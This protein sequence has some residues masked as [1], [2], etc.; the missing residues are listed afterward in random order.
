MNNQPVKL[1]KVLVTGAYGFVGRTLCRELKRRGYPVR[2]SVRRIGKYSNAAEVDKNESNVPAVD[3]VAV[4][5]IGPHTDWTKAV[6]GIDVIMHLAGRAHVLHEIQSSSLEA[7]R[8]TNTFGTECLASTAAD[9]GIKR[10]IF[11]S[12]I[13]VNG[14]ATS[15]TPFTELS[16][17]SPH[18][19]YAI[20]KWEAEQALSRIA[21]D[22]GMELVVLRPPLVYGPDAPGYFARLIRLIKIGFPL[23]LGDIMN[24]RSFV[25][26]GNLVD[27]I[28]K[29]A[30]RP[31][32]AGET[33]LV[34][35]G[36]DLST[37]DLIRMIASEMD[38]TPAL[39]SCPT[40]LLK[41]LGK[42]TG[43]SSKVHQLIYS[44]CI[45]SSKI[46]NKLDW[47]PPFSVEEGIKETVKQFKSV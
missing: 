15:E 31:E 26:V 7:F 46:R 40:F 45:D 33:F 17:P 39:I 8:H 29:C 32:A 11:I 23:P 41:L 20:S 30:N 14:N 24:L 28:V 47:R 3:I 44:L 35:D 1:P 19:P 10:F 18:N 42:L 13:G 22:A 2:G 16:P 27:A 38:K 25:Y 34:S 36:H 5:N 12:S 9:S 4:G 6:E 37:P 21:G 43:K